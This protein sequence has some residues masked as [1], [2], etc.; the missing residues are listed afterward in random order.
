[1][2][3]DTS[4]MKVGQPCWLAVSLDKTQW[5]KTK[6]DFLNSQDKWVSKEDPYGVYYEGIIAGPLNGT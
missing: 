6:H 3:I 1:M 5:L 4:W 2:S